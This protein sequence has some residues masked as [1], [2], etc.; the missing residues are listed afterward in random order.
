V[1]HAERLQSAES[2]YAEQAA[3]LRKVLDT[4]DAAELEVIARFLERL[5]QPM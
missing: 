1:L 3:N 4:F 5:N 2:P